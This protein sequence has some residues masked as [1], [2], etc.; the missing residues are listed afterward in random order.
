MENQAPSGANA[1]VV[2]IYLAIALLMIVSLWKCFNK[3]GLPGWGILIPIYNV[4]LI[5]K[6]AGRPGWW[7]VLLFI[8]LVNVVIDVIV[9]IDI[10]RKFGKGTGFGVGIFF[11]PFVFLPAI[12]FGDARYEGSVLPAAA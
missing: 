11:L 1:V 9:S 10:A 6:L 5:V 4:Y 7:L 12:A 2:I 3:A 8:P